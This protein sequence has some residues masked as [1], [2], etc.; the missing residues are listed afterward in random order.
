MVRMSL[1]SLGPGHLVSSMSERTDIVYLDYTYAR[2]MDCDPDY[3]AAAHS[4]GKSHPNDGSGDFEDWHECVA[5][6]MIAT[7]VGMPFVTDADVDVDTPFWGPVN[8][9]SPLRHAEDARIGRYAFSPTFQRH[10][11][12]DISFVQADARALDASLH[13]AFNRGAR[14]VWIKDAAV[15][16]AFIARVTEPVIPED[17]AWEI[18]RNEEIGRAHV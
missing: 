17:M 13:T 10:S 16:K 8:N 14:A 15:S 18:V 3:D 4:M 1:R 7:R 12:R 6:A 2:P 11:G 9:W 5:R